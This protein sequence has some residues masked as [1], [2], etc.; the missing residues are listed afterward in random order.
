MAW[1][2]LVND[3]W[4]S[5]PTPSTR[6]WS[7]QDLSS[8]SS[9]RD[10]NGNMHKDIASVKRKNECTWWAKSGAVARAIMTAAKSKTFIQLRYFDPYD[11]AQ[12]EITC[13]TGDIIAV[14]NNSQYGSVWEVRLSFIEQ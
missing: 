10:L 13:Y 8:D 6:T 1:E 12:K 4:T 9:G 7:Y 14:E 5:I 3:V 2:V 11:N